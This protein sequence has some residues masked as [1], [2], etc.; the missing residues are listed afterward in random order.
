MQTYFVVQ[1]YAVNAKRQIEADPPRQV[2]TEADA[3]R[4]AERLSET[5]FGV[6]A[7]SRTGDVSTGEWEEAKVLFKFGDFPRE[8]ADELSQI[9]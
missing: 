8:D 9:A 1:T 6:L 7:F 5:K 3:V 4:L 2:P